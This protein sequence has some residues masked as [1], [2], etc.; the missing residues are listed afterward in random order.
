MT[1]SYCSLICCHSSEANIMLIFSLVL[2]LLINNL[3]SLGGFRG[4]K[5]LPAI[6]L[7]TLMHGNR[8]ASELV[9]TGFSICCVTLNHI[10]FKLKCVTLE[11]VLVLSCTEE[12]R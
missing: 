6:C 1:G 11:R 3:C 9:V 4:D 7:A 2:G 12:L 8:D 10:K 5:S